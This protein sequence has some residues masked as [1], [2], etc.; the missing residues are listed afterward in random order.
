MLY[1]ERK[2]KKGKRYRRQPN[3]V[4]RSDDTGLALSGEADVQL[5]VVTIPPDTPSVS[6]TRFQTTCL[7]FVLRFENIICRAH[8]CPFELDLLLGWEVRM[9]LSCDRQF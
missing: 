4:R 2:E 6:Q 8:R 7:E 1:A 3:G 9:F 5:F